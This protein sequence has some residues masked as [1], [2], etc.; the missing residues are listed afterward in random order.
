MGA[1]L[2]KFLQLR[3]IGHILIKTKISTFHHHNLLI[4]PTRACFI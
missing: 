4:R 3:F 2:L 1:R